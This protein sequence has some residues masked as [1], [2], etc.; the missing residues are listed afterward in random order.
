MLKLKKVSFVFIAVIML[1]VFSVNGQSVL[2]P[3]LEPD[4]ELEKVFNEKWEAELTLGGL[5]NFGPVS[6]AENPEPLGLER[7]D[8]RIYITRNLPKGMSVTGAYMYRKNAPFDTIGFEHRITEQFNFSFAA[9]L[10]DVTNRIRLEQR[11]KDDEYENRLRYRISSDIPFQGP[12]ID[13]GEAFLIVSEGLVFSFNKV[14]RSL[15]NRINLG[16]G[17][18]L[19]E[20]QTVDLTAEYRYEGP[21]KAQ[22]LHFITG[23]SYSF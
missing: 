10:I 22:A 19:K 18:K 14:G 13:P 8:S 11:I 21:H 3:K 12:E 15:E 23:Y 5:Y 7:L 20:T 1:L 17:W 6:P 16:V 4:L 9:G 2:Y